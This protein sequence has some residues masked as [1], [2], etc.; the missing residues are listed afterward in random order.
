M[1]RPS[2]IDISA[3]TTEKKLLLVLVLVGILAA[4]SQVR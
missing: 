3:L 2:L 4:I 1:K